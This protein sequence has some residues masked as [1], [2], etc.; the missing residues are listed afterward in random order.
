[1]ARQQL[2][3]NQLI[4]TFGPGAM[5]DLPHNSIIIGG[6]ESWRYDR[7]KPCE[8]TEP[9]LSAKLGRIFGTKSLRLKMPPPASDSPFVGGRIT[10]GVGG[11]VFPHWFMVQKVELSPAK[12]KRRRLVHK[13]ELTPK[14]RFQLDKKSWPVVPIR[15]VRACR[16]GH[17]GDIQ[18]REFVH[19]GPCLCHMPLWLE[20]RGTTGD[21]SDI[22][23]VCECGAIRCVRESAQ[24]KALGGC[25]GSRPWL[26]DFDQKGCGED[27]R[28]LI[29]T[30][31]NAY[32]PQVIVSDFHSGQ[33]E[34]S[35]RDCSGDVGQPF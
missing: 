12:H 35:R 7:D 3:S 34:Q 14:A 15:F 17:V 20:E 11:Y 8:V 9:R 33:P 5:V 26:G 32:F 21:L 23:I 19:G 25:N 31:S 13:D 6:L 16:K 2:R 1:M 24:E 27:N 28:L 22:W 10:P 29:R 30:A 18:W 4:T